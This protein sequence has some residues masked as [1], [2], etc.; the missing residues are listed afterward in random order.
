M[1]RIKP[2]LTIRTWKKLTLVLPTL[3]LLLSA[4]PTVSFADNGHRGRGHAYGHYKKARVYSA[5]SWVVPRHIYV[6]NYNT[7]QPYFRG[8]A[9]YG[10]H[11]HYHSTY[12]F[13][14]YVNGFVVYRPYAYCGDQIFIS[15]SAPLPRL[16]FNVSFGTPLVV[17][18]VP[19]FPVGGLH[20]LPGR[21]L[22][23]Q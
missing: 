16:A 5:P 21:E 23:R 17:Y 10:P 14:V 6:E 1:N 15:A 7:Y 13:P 22:G 20:Q 8:R 19:P 9:Y 18:G 12:Q 11:R 3:I 2:A 4:I